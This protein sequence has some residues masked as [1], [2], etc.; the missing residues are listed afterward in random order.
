MPARRRRYEFSFKGWRSKD[1][2][3]DNKFIG[4]KRCYLVEQFFDLGFDF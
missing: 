3:Y 2:R 1:R 4:E